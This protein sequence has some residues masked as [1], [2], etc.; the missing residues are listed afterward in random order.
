MSELYPPR[1]TEIGV[2]DAEVVRLDEE[3]RKRVLEY[4]KPSKFL[5]RTGVFAKLIEESASSQ[6]KLL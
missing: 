1:Q 2:S 3:T 4:E 5:E 6:D